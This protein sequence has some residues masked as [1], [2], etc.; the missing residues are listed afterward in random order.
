M[1]TTKQCPKCSSHVIGMFPDVRQPIAAK[2]GSNSTRGFHL[3]AYFCGECGYFEQY[4]QALPAE[5]QTPLEDTEMKFRWI[6]PPA[7]SQG[8]YR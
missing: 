1:K 2:D 8:P 4:L 7:E 6:R 3:E 5:R